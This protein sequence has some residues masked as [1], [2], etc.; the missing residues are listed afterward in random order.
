MPLTFEY[1]KS[2][3]YT[4]YD[5]LI[6]G[7]ASTG[8]VGIPEG[9][10]YLTQGLVV[11]F[12]Y[13]PTNFNLS[14]DNLDDSIT[15]QVSRL[16]IIN[17]GAEKKKTARISMLPPIAPD[18]APVGYEY[19]TTVKIQLSKGKNEI[20]VSQGNNTVLLIVT[21]T[22]F[23][24]LLHGYADELFNYS[25]DDYQR[26]YNEIYSPVGTRLAEPFLTVSDMFPD[27]QTLQLLASKMSIR[28]YISEQGGQEGVTDFLSG[29][30]QSTPYFKDQKN[31]VNFDPIV[32]PIYRL[33]E[34]FSG[35]EAHVW[36]PNVSLVRW[37]AFIK[38]VNNIKTVYTLKKVTEEEVVVEVDGVLQSHTFD[39]DLEES[40]LFFINMERACYDSLH[41]YMSMSLKTA[42]T[43]C[44]AG[45]PFD[46]I[47]NRNNPLYGFD[48]DY[49]DF[50]GLSLTGRLDG[51]FTFDTMVA[52]EFSGNNCTYQN[53]YYTQTPLTVDT[54]IDAPCSITVT[55]SDS[56]LVLGKGFGVGSYGSEGYSR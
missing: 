11:P 45:Y 26:Q 31:K 36:I 34:D 46:L 35:V 29:L 18:F 25:Y 10:F 6:H 3:S 30:V 40:S 14:T 32:Q 15:I 9:P 21:A 44:A 50:V 53:S 17:L 33:Q 55:G 8:Q 42:F 27:V 56:L 48:I 47:I 28:Q 19:T 52:K 38:F 49:P 23:G 39:F 22:V 13:Y 43:M 51:G 37:Q 20:V 1:S 16:G 2:P 24:A 4:I 12:S 7:D 54:E 41:S 5:R